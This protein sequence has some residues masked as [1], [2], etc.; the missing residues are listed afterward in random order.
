MANYIESRFFCLNCGERG[1]DCLRKPSKK[2]K[3]GHR[4]KMFCPACGHTCNFYEVLSDNDIKE[5][6]QKFARG[7]FKEEAAASI[8]QSKKDDW[9]YFI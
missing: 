7:E 2:K 1:I 6:K 9:W 8:E 3:A 5:F 4:K